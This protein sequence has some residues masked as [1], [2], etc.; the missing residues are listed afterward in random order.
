MIHQQDQT[1]E[2]VFG[3]LPPSEDKRQLG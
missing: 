1:P 2:C 3:L